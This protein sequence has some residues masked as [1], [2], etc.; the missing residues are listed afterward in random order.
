M[1]QPFELIE[2]PTLLL[3]ETIARRNIRRMVA[4]VK[5]AENQ[6]LRFRPHFKTHQSAEIGEWF[7]EEGVTAIT[8]S[9][10]DMAL[11]FAQQGWDDIT[12]AFPANLRQA[13][14]LSGLAQ[15]IRLGLLVESTETAQGLAN[16]LD[17]T[18]DIWIKIDVGAHRTGLPWDQPERIFQVAQ[19]V[20]AAPNLRLRG[21]LTHAGQIYQARSVEEVCEQYELSVTLLRELRQELIQYGLEGLEISVGDTPG[22]SLVPDLGQVD[23]IRPGNFVFYD[24]QQLQIGSCSWEDVAVALACPVV[25]LHPERNEVVVYG[26]AVHLSKDFLIENGQRNY[27]YVCLPAGET[28]GPPLMGAYVSALSQEHGIIRMQPD[29]LQRVQI[30]ELLCVLPA[31][32]CLTV[33]LMKRYLTTTGRALYTMNT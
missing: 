31:H 12:L 1:S 20:Q 7:R 28:W 30:G 17:S 24:A 18:T 22:A 11:Y 2:K 15:Q 27:G 16:T 5:R 21:L 33:T 23:E 8:V 10:V 9:S 25:A 29:D 13:K 26:G 32:S 14:T 3:D 4:R 6:A 19:A